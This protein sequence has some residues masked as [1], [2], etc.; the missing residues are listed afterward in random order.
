MAEWKYIVNKASFRI[1]KTLFFPVKRV[2]C[3]LCFLWD[4]SFL[5]WVGY[6]AIKKFDL[7]F[8]LQHR[9]ASTFFTNLYGFEGVCSLHL[10]LFTLTF[11][12][13]YIYNLYK[14]SHFCRL[15]ASKRTDSKMYVTRKNN[16]VSE[17]PR[18]SRR[19]DNTVAS[20]RSSFIV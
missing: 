15:Y 2:I 12:V 19:V 20:I 14:L 4:F 13:S 18:R 6:V 7:K 17:L 10:I 9:F 3:E 11:F 16:T 8:R 5:W 1:I